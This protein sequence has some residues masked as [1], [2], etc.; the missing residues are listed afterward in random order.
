MYATQVQ[1]IMHRSKLVDD[2]FF[3]V[4]ETYNSHNMANTTVLLEYLRPVSK[5]YE[6]ELL[7]LSESKY[8]EKHLQYHLPVDTKLT[9]EVGRIEMWLTFAYTELDA[10]G[11][12]TQ[13]VRKAGPVFIEVLPTATWADIIPDSALSA[14]DQ[15]LIK[16]DAQMRGLS[17]FA[18]NIEASAVDDI[19][20]D[21]IE[22]TIQLTANG[23]G[24]GSKISVKDMLDDGIPVVDIGSNSSSDTPK[25]DD[26]IVEF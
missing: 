10:S 6:T 18:Q 26:D 7:V 22:E 9:A 4:E 25:E 11:N 23:V 16:L 2:L 13:H 19:K 15:R 3:I 20:F 21:D 8:N 12:N 24:V 14:L 17:D 5:K 1:R